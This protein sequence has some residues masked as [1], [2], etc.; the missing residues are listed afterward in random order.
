MAA[1]HRDNGESRLRLLDA[2]ELSRDVGPRPEESRANVVLRSTLAVIEN[3]TSV[4]RVVASSL[5]LDSQG[6]SNK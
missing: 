4:A 3:S 1:Y 6:C 5:V 2:V